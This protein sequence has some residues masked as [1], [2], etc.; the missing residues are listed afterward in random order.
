MSRTLLQVW[1]TRLQLKTFSP[2]IQPQSGP[3]IF[4]RAR[5]ASRPSAPGGGRGRSL[6]AQTWCQRRERTL[7]HTTSTVLW[8]RRRMLG[9]WSGRPLMCS[10]PWIHVSCKSGSD[11]SGHIDMTSSSCRWGGYLTEPV[12][13]S[14]KYNPQNPFL[15]TRIQARGLK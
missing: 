9:R 15:R 10:C 4:N 3:M 13:P 12:N 2:I 14:R 11:A 7:V 6:G 8:R 1:A 5:P